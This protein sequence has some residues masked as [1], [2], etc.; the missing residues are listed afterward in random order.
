M[1]AAT[2]LMVAGCGVGDTDKAAPPA[3]KPKQSASATAPPQAEEKTRDDVVE[4]FRYA[5]KDLAQDFRDG[6]VEPQNRH[7]VTNLAVLTRTAPER[8]DLVKVVHSLEERGW[9]LLMPESEIRPGDGSGIHLSSGPWRITI[10][11]GPVPP[12]LKGQAADNLGGIALTGN[13]R[14]Q[15]PSPLLQPPTKPSHM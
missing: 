1:A 10:G 2:V 7:C 6:P 8:S 4:D 15:P 5:T 3:P 13:R 14:C 11:G 9:K 12:E